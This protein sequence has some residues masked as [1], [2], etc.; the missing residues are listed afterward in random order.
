MHVDTLS[1]MDLS[2]LVSTTTVVYILCIVLVVAIIGVA[3]TYYLHHDC[4]HTM[5]VHAGIA[6]GAQ[7]QYHA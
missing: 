1:Q 3:I 2:L 6:T 7:Q 4:M 5:T